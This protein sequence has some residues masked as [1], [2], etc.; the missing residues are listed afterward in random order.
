[1]GESLTTPVQT[2]P[3]AHPASCKMDTESFPVLMRPGR[4]VNH[5]PPSS[6]A[7]KERVELY[8]YSP[9]GLRSLFEGELDIY[10]YLMALLQVTFSSGLH[11]P[12]NKPT[13]K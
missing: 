4:G 12:Y 8:L 9:L 6:A 2:G 11:G 1:M 3:G 5:Q 13:D 7:V 10:V